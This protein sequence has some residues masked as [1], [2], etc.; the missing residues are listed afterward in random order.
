MADEGGAELA[1]ERRLK[2]SALER[3]LTVTDPSEQLPAR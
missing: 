2:V 1:I 3:E